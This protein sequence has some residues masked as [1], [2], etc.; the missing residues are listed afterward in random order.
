MD[1]EEDYTMTHRAMSPVSYGEVNPYKDRLRDVMDNLG[2]QVIKWMGVVHTREP[3]TAA[4]HL[5]G[6]DLMRVLKL[7]KL[8]Y[9]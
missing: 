2:W 7:I 3:C 9:A 1:P 6:V 5:M 8:K 4:I